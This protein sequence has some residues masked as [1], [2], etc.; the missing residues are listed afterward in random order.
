MLYP[1]IDSLVKLVDSKYTL[2]I[3]ASRR[4]R[5]LQEKPLNVTGSS[6]TMNVSRALW[7]ISDGKLRYVRTSEEEK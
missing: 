5:R 2:V 1:S 7:E 6:T 4:A 3:V